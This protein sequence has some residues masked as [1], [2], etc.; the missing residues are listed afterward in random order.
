MFVQAL[1]FSKKTLK[2]IYKGGESVNEGLWFNFET[3]LLGS[4]FA[5]KTGTLDRFLVK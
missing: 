2:I 4:I 3:N 5:T 1:Q